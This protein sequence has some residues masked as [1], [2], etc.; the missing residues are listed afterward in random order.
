MQVTTTVA[1]RRVFLFASMRAYEVSQN[2]LLISVKEA[3]K[4]LGKEAEQLSDD[5]VEALIIT[6]TT[7]GSQFLRSNTVPKNEGA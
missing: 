4:L 6:L 2:L 7:V 5:Q 1:V 3:R